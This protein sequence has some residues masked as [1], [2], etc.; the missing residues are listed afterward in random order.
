MNY[1]EKLKAAEEKLKKAETTFKRLKAL[2]DKKTRTEETRK[3]VLAGAA[4]LNFMSKTTDEKTK[5]Y[6]IELLKRNLEPK[7]FEYLNS[8]I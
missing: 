3:K 4:L 6:L 1:D 2:N 8:R 5:N 7:D